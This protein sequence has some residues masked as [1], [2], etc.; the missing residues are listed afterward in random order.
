M[1][2][3]ETTVEVEMGRAELPEL[4]VG[5]TTVLKEVGTEAAGEVP[6]GVYSS[7][8]RG[9][10]KCQQISNF[11]SHSLKVEEKVR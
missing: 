11:R 5:I 4:K 8:G 1:V 3:V 7:G 2:A 6:V 9:G 10:E